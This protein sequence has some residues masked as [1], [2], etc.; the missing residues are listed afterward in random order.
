[1]GSTV[2]LL[3]NADTHSD[4]EMATLGMKLWPETFARTEDVIRAR[5]LFF[6]T[7]IERG[8]PLA[9]LA[10]ASIAAMTA[11]Q[12]AHFGYPTLL[13]GHKMAAALMST[14]AHLDSMDDVHVPWLA[15]RCIVPD[16]LLALPD[17][18]PIDRIM[19]SRR[20]ARPSG[21]GA[22]FTRTGPMAENESWAVLW[23]LEMYANGRKNGSR[24]H[25]YHTSLHGLLTEALEHAIE[26]E[27]HSSTLL[28][29]SMRATAARLCVCAQ[30]YVLGLLVLVQSHPKFAGQRERPVAP[31]STRRD[32]PPNH[33][34]FMMGTPID[35]DCRPAVRAY[36]LGERAAPPSVQ[37]WVIGHWKRQV[38]GVGRSG[39]KVIW[40]QPY[41]R[42]PE[43]APILVRPYRVGD[44]S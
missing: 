17:G 24:L 7:M 30:R 18:T 35:L 6:S 4:E 39:R 22:P 20:V 19:L 16:G 36:L 23:S 12:W 8:F 27:D 9:T 43:G 38:I 3:P 25:L 42:G 10:T 32:G 13:T 41:W 21:D 40:V 34:T 37:S 15:F 1:M 14:K 33:R 29:R 26:V 5:Q 44:E 28:D 11:A 31:T 2:V